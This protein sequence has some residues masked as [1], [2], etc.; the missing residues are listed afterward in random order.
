MSFSTISQI[1]P[2]LI[3]F[4][5]LIGARGNSAMDKKMQDVH[6]KITQDYASVDHLSIAQFNE[7]ESEHVVLFD[8]R[9]KSE[10]SVSH[11]ANAVQVEP[12]ISTEDFINQYQDFIGDKTIV[13]YCSVGR[14]SSELAERVDAALNED[15][16]SEVYNL[17]GGLFEWHNKDLPLVNDRGQTNLIHPYNR[18]WGEL[19][20]DESA[21]SYQ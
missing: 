13:F 19:I 21:I 14:R 11:V 3:L 15:S 20:H 5:M 16:F 2:F 6:S 18:K 7:L 17:T 4:S 1:F 9:E 8:V 10:Y 12:T